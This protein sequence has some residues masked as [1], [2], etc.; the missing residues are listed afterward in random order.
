MTVWNFQTGPVRL[1]D[2]FPTRLQGG[3]EAVVRFGAFA[4][5]AGQT[6]IVALH[7]AALLQWVAFALPCRGIADMKRATARRSLATVERVSAAT[8]G[9]THARH[10]LIDGAI[11]RIAHALPVD[12]GVAAIAGGGIAV[13]AGLG[14]CLSRQLRSGVAPS[15]RLGI[16]D[17]RRRYGHSTETEQ[18]LQHLTPATAGCHRAYE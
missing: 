13:R 7:V 4:I 2:H 9:N 14:C 8:V 10:A 3:A 15:S 12:T 6:A 11:G 17:D 18:A 16:V 5:D 1:A